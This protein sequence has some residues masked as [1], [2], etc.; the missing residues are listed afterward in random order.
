MAANDGRPAVT[1][2]LKRAGAQPALRRAAPLR[3][4][5]ET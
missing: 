2:N 4:E 5:G 3:L 1:L